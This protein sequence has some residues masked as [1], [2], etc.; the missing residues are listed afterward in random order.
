M[1]LDHVPSSIALRLGL[2]LL[3]LANIVNFVVRKSYGN[4]DFLTGLLFGCS[5]GL[6]M[7]ALWRNRGDRAAS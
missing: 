1:C 5:F 2:A 6:L 3:A 7:L 4:V